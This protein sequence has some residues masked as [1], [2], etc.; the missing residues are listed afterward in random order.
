MA[1]RILPGLVSYSTQVIS[2]PLVGPKHSAR[3][4]PSPWEQTKRGSPHHLLVAAYFDERWT[5]KVLANEKIG[6]LARRYLFY[7]RFEP[8]LRENI[9]T[10]YAFRMDWLLEQLADEQG[11]FSIDPFE[12]EP[13]YNFHADTEIVETSVERNRSSAWIPITSQPFVELKRSLL[14]KVEKEFPPSKIVGK[15]PEGWLHTWSN[16]PERPS[17]LF[18]FP[19]S[20]HPNDVLNDLEDVRLE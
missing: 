20:G 4:L 8:I 18:S 17:K 2:K 5:Q 14:R 1:Q 10:K 12:G 11:S 16:L 15:K 3:H 6:F 9:P 13:Q 7:P 19:T